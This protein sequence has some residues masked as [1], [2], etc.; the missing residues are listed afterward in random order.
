MQYMKTFNLTATAAEEAYNFVKEGKWKDAVSKIED[1]DS[2]PVNE[3]PEGKLLAATEAIKADVANIGAWFTGPKADVV[4]AISKLTSIMAGDK[5]FAATAAKTTEILT[6]AGLTGKDLRGADKAF[7]KALTSTA[8]VDEDDNGENDYAQ[9]AKSILNATESLPAGYEFRSAMHQ[10]NLFNRFTKAE[11]FTAENT[12]AALR[13]I[14]YVKESLKG[15][16]EEDFKKEYAQWV[17]GQIQDNPYSRKDDQL[18]YILAEKPESLPVEIIDTITKYLTPN[19]FGR[20]AEISS[21]NTHGPN[22]SEV[23]QIFKALRSFTDRIPELAKALEDAAKLE[24]VFRDNS[25]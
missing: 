17:S 11:D 21:T 13:D 1:V 9:R 2:K 5:K 25:P 8:K 3:T 15:R 20:G 6:G 23:D 10:N 19:I 18:K 7:T 24:V 16:T 12:Q 22:S 4:D 14:G